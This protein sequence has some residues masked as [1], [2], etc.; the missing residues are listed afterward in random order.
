[1]ESPEWGM[2]HSL[3]QVPVK[4]AVFGRFC[5][6]RAYRDRSETYRQ[7]NI[8]SKHTVHTYWFQYLGVT[9]A[10]NTS[11]YCST[12]TI[13]T[14]TTSGSQSVDSHGPCEWVPVELSLPVNGLTDHIVVWVEM[15]QALQLTL[16][17]WLIKFW[18]Y[19]QSY[20]VGTLPK[21]WIGYITDWHL[22]TIKAIITH[23][24]KIFQA[25]KDMEQWVS[26]YLPRYIF[27][28]SITPFT[29]PLNHHQ[30]LAANFKMK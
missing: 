22:P 24:N 14:Y 29:F 25:R 5:F 30:H 27:M 17:S 20:H 15:E 6:A 21:N 1:M 28:I 3:L 12:C 26:R 2:M 11:I 23:Y 16:D 19:L 4:S 8:N 10:H 9:Q 7:R 18:P 13:S